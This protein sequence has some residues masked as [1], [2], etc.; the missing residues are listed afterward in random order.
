MKGS[1]M[2]VIRT[3]GDELTLHNDADAL[4]AIQDEVERDGASGAAVVYDVVAAR[5]AGYEMDASVRRC[6]ERD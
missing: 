6:P 2:M 4:G 1:A 3:Y 5:N